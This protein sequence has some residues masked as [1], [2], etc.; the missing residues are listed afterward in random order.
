MSLDILKKFR[1]ENN[2]HKLPSDPPHPAFQG[3][4]EI[5]EIPSSELERPITERIKCQERQSDRRER[6][7]GDRRE[8]A[9]QTETQ[10]IRQTDRETH[11]T[12]SCEKEGEPPPTLDL[13]KEVE[14]QGGDEGEV[15]LQHNTRLEDIDEPTQSTLN[16]D[17]QEGV[18]GVKRGPSEG[19]ENEIDMQEGV[20]GV[21]RGQ[22]ECVENKCND[23][24]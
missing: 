19:V 2:V 4:D 8:T 18:T 13:D 9:G 24:L 10:E 11:I 20:T 6:D 17:M 14:M 21:K 1:G 23:K 12:S 7:P 16:I 15:E 3:G 22:A 5:T